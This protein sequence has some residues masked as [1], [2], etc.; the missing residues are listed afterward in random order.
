MPW[1]LS[2]PAAVLPLRRFTP[3]PLDFAALVAG[4]MT[5][6]LGYYIDRFDLSTFAHTL[7]GSFVACL[8]TGVIFLL[9]FYLFCKPFCYALP[10]PH[11]QVL[12]PLC[13]V[14]PKGLTRWAIIIFSLLLGTWTHNF[15]DAFTH[16]HGW[17]VDR[18]TWLQQP[19]LQVPSTT[20]CVYL[21]L[22]ELSTVVGFV[23]VAIAYARWLR[24]QPVDRSKASESDRWRYLLWAAIVIVSLMISLPPALRIASEFHGFLFYRSLA[25]QTA[26]DSPDIAIPLS[27][28]VTTVIYAH[29]HRRT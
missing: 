26:I 24:R 23:I 29:R 4:S 25:F 14:F 8:P 9:V 22:Q 11:R 19:V 6:D 13:P 16:E 3:W 18:I 28:L 12:L 21:A 10:A 20:I 2:H 27:L 5:P 1:T 17:F 15:W 7:P